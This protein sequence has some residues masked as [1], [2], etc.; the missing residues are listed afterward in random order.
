[1]RGVRNP[2]E[3]SEQTDHVI[4]IIFCKNYVTCLGAQ[5]NQNKLFYKFQREEAHAAHARVDRSESVAN[6][7][8]HEWIVDYIKF[9][10]PLTL[11]RD[12]IATLE[13]ELITMPFT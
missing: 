4:N 7:L 8:S 10:L 13:R 3:E 12:V 6:S 1:M 2:R 5:K 9:W 11:L